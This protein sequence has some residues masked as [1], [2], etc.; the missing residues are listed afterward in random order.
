MSAALTLQAIHLVV[1]IVFF[2]LGFLHDSFLWLI[3]VVSCVPFV[4]YFPAALWYGRERSTRVY[5]RA[6]AEVAYLS[7]QMALWMSESIIPLHPHYMLAHRLTRPQRSS[8]LGCI[9]RDPTPARG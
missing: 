7:I 2:I 4:V 3:A 9:T 6:G 5:D 1:I 8:S